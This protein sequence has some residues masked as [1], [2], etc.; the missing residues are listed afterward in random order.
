[1]IKRMDQQL[2]EKDLKIREAQQE[3]ERLA[4]QLATL[5]ERL[6]NMKSS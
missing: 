1:V 5:Y 3:I 2:L 6:E 4:D